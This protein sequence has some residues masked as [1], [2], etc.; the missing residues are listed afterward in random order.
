[1]T[2][3]W[4]AEEDAIALWVTEPDA[5]TPFGPGTVMGGDTFWSIASQ[6]APAEGFAQLVTYG[7]IPD[8]ADDTTETNGGPFQ[9]LQVGG[10]Y[11]VTVATTA[12]GVGSRTFVWDPDGL[13]RVE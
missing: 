2:L 4:D 3:G 8:G 12:F 11:K 6:N 5:M 13:P 7:V 10:C 9:E 1:M